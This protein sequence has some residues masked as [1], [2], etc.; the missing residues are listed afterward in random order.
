[1]SPAARARLVE[2]HVPRRVLDAPEPGGWS[3]RI[4]HG[5][6][7]VLDCDGE[8]MGRYYRGCEFER[9]DSGGGVSGT[10][11]RYSVCIRGWHGEPS[12]WSVKRRV[13]RR[14]HGPARPP[15]PEV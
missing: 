6:V 9:D 14:F 3:F 5:T 11:A 8:E 12:L 2:F 4:S 15:T 1:M 10:G 13:D 7:T